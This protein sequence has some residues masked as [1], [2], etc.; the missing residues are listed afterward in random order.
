MVPIFPMLLGEFI[1]I[2][3]GSLIIE[4]IFSVPGVGELYVDAINI[5]DFDVF[6]FLCIFY[7]SIGLLSGLVVDLSYG[8]VDPR[9]RMGGKK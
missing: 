9:I 5:K 1:G 2:I 4:K 7:V 3:G 6:L 8:F